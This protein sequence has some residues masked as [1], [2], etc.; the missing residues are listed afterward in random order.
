MTSPNYL[1]QTV[2]Q[3]ALSYLL[4]RLSKSQQK[5]KV[6]LDKLLVFRNYLTLF[7]STEINISKGVIYASQKGY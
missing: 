2:K 4:V 1:R 7:Y 5:V 3:L 6:P